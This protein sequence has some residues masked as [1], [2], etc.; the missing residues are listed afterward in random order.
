[1]CIRDRR[2]ADLILHVRDISHAETAEQAAD[3]V[4]NLTSLGV[5][6]SVPVLEVW[7]K[8]DLVDAS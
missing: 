8:L 6:P 4:D 2:E 1:M 7:N 5:R 3:V